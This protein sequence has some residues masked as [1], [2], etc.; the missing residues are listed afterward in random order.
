MGNVVDFVV[1][2]TTE[3]LDG[4]V[5]LRFADE[6]GDVHDLNAAELADVLQGLVEFTGQ[7]ARAGL[8]GDGVPPEVRVRPPQQG[9]V[10]VEAIVQWTGENPEAAAGM[11][12][13]TAGAGV[14]YSLKV[15]LRKLRGSEVADFEH[16]E[17]GNVKLN[18]SDGTVSEVQATVWKVLNEQKRSTKRAL[19][20]ILAPLSDDVDRL[21]IRDGRP[22]DETRDV[23]TAEPELVMD[24]TDYRTAAHES[25]DEEEEISTFDVEA[26]L[27]SID[28]RTGEKWRVRTARGARQATIED[29]DFLRQLDEGMALHK[30]DL[31]DVTVHEV[32]TTRNGR[33]TRE[34]S[35]TKV[36]RKRQGGHDGGDTP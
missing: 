4:V 7:M 6:R 25:D 22:E 5:Q 12:F 11:L 2:R 36:T 10:I 27:T 1:D 20:K 17:N 3:I 29:D 24:R 31:F 14:V 35:L 8:F 21:E 19:R 13:P 28:F 23:L 15:A 32:A 33:T 30:N 26:Q 16:L 18:W 34:W 9:S